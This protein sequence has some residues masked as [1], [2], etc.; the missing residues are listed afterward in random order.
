[1]YSAFSFC[2]LITR[3]FNT[4]VAHNYLLALVLDN[5]Y[6]AETRWN[7]LLQIQN[8]MQQTGKVHCSHLSDTWKNS[9]ES[10]HSFSP[11]R[12]EAAVCH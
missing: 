10:D 12:S 6:Y 8:Y 2:K 7:L 5:L 1:M 11:Y 9:R 3:C 4:T